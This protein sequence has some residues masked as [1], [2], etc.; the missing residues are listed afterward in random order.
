M[1]RWE[2]HR[3]RSKVALLLLI[4]LVALLGGK[5]TALITVLTLEWFGEAVAW[6]K[7]PTKKLPK[8]PRSRAPHDSLALPATMPARLD[9]T[10]RRQA[11]LWHVIGRDDTLSTI[12]A[13]YGVSVAALRQAN[14]LGP[15]SRLV[16]GEALRIPVAAA[17]QD[18][19]ALPHRAAAADG[20]RRRGG[21]RQL[22]PG[23]PASLQAQAGFRWPVAGALTSS[24]GERDDVMGGAGVQFHAGIDLSVSTGTPVVAAQSGLVVVAGPYGAYGKA[25][26]L[27]HAQ[28]FSTLYA[29]NSRLLV[30]VG[31]RV[32]AGEVICLSGNTG[33]S[34]GPHVHFEVHKDGWPVDPLPHLP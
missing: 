27:D 14:Y 17:A 18:R 20:G 16:V 34:T 9:D 1:R 4:N 11:L 3:T 30:Q 32:K 10:L 24:Y 22:T 21:R 33:R 31:Q 5:S 28:G 23:A 6:A 29:H 13:S 8:P 15:T 19:G 7:A 26:K 2:P 12:A 25:V